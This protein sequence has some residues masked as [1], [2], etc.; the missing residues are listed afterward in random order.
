ML[1][2]FNDS[3]PQPDSK[4]HLKLQY[5]AFPEAFSSTKNSFPHIGQIF[6]MYSI[7]KPY[8]TFKYLIL[9]IFIYKISFIRKLQHN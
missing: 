6:L 9:S 1:S 4:R 7:I 2:V 3:T 8:S 5:S